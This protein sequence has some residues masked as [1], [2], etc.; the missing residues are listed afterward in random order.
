VFT[1]IQ[2]PADAQVKPVALVLTQATPRDNYLVQ[3]AVKLEAHAVLPEV[4]P[5]SVGAARLPENVPLLVMRP[6]ELALA[7]G[8]ILDKGNASPF[9]DKFD[10]HDDPL[11]K[12]IGIDSRNTLKSKLPA[13]AIMTFTNQKGPADSVALATSGSGALVAVYLEE[14][15]EV[16]PVEGGAS[17][18]AEGAVKSL[19][20][21]TSTTKGT[22]AI[23]GDQLLF[24]VPAAGSNGKIVLLGWDTGLVS[25]K[26]L[27]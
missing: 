16:K 10:L 17:V 23:Y 25:A 15:V 12:Q 8:D 14:N 21:V 27:P 7:F 13:S 4:A 11:L 9:L 20:K 24:A 2:N 3:Y 6:S 1:V 22:T 18:N 5:A 26:E 19:S